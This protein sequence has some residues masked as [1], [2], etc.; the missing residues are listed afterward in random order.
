MSVLT[1]MPLIL[2]M[3]VIPNTTYAIPNVEYTQNMMTNI[4]FGK[5][6]PT[7]VKSNIWFEDNYLLLLLAKGRRRSVF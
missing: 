1:N 6:L 4:M 5:L 3:P 7:Q 2:T